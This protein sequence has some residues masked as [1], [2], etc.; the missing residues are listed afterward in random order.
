MSGAPQPPAA[1]QAAAAAANRCRQLGRGDALVWWP[2]QSS[3]QDAL[4]AAALRGEASAGAV[5]VAEHQT[6]GRGRG[7]NQWVCPPGAGLTFSAL[8]PWPASLESAP[9]LS[10]AAALALCRVAEDL[11]LRP[12]VKWPNDVEL[13]GRKLAG[14]L[15][16]LLATPPGGA[17]LVLVGVGLNVG[18]DPAAL[19]PTLASQASSLAEA[20]G[21]PPPR[22][23]LLAAALLALE[24][25]AELAVAAPAALLE[26]WRA[27]WPHRGRR[28]RVEA[29]PG[30]PLRGRIADLGPDGALLFEVDGQ[31]RAVLA[32][33][34]R[35]E[36]GA[37]AAPELHPQGR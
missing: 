17:P 9:L 27:R 22:G 31:V 6:A 25:A 30:A 7:G 2:T 10:F 37:A 4:R 20:P 33:T 16:E 21:G 14:I 32:G 29:P 13:G 36:E 19:G 28:A 24:R 1:L 3:T 5:W 23:P 15:L 11:G 26:Q 8:L 34:L 35:L 12:T 18:L